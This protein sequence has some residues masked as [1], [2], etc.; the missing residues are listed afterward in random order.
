MAYKCSIC[1]MAS[2]KRARKK[3]KERLV[4][5]HGGMCI[6]CG[7]NRYAGS[8]QFHH[9]DPSTKT[10]QVS[11]LGPCTRRAIEEAEKCV[12]LCANC[13]FEVEAGI[14]NLPDSVIGRPEP[15]QG[16]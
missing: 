8:L 6:I 14:T 3:A 7:Y 5:K 10:G 9:L 1:N 2:I 11:S 13:H 4:H 15:F 16:S 12:L